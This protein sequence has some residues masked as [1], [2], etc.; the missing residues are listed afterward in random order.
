[1]REGYKM[2]ELGEIPEEWKIDLLENLGSTYSGLSGKSKDDFGI[3]KPY[4]PYM[5]VFSK[6]KINPDFLDYVSINPTEFQNK[7]R[8]GD[9]LFTV[10]SET[11]DEV[12]MSSVLLQDFDELYLNS[13]CF[14]FRLN[15]FSSLLPEYATYLF[16]G[17]EV[18]KVITV[19][20]QGSTRFNLSK[21]TLVKKLYVKLPPLPEQQKI[22]TILSTV[23]EKIEVIDAQI[24]QTR[25][26]KK[27][28]MQKL[29]TCGIGHT[30]FK[31]SVLG[32][33]PESWE[34]DLL[35]NVSKRVSGHTPSKSFGSYYNGGIKWISLADSSSLDKGL[36][37]ETK[38]NISEEGVKNSS[39][40]VHPK[41]TVLMSRDAGVGKSAVMGEEMAVSQHFIAWICE[42]KLNNWYLYYLLQFKKEYFERI[43]VGSTIK[44]IGLPIFKKLQILV[45][46]VS[47]QNQIATILN[48]MDD[49]LDTLQAKKE[50]YQQLKK[51]LMQQ[52]L[53]G[54][55]RVAGKE[56]LKVEMYEV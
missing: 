20:S 10:S 41:G 30:K 6:G 46:P 45:P 32:E 52:L 35:D 39:A 53:T 1:M 33:I 3:G 47:E 38:F 24:T 16:R 29:L 49:K 48:T 2:T 7:V 51:G 8:Y 36:I 31:D 56:T 37:F 18:R 5:N 9:I 55:V 44:T 43:A 23:D 50:T 12:G 25:E 19:L 42:A 4:I 17:D 22:A 13:F 40:V 54:K 34:V 21:N 14:G 11:V 26:L 27:G 15:D 28:L